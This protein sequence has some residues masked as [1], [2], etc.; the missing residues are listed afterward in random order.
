MTE[1]QLIRSVFLATVPLLV[2]ALGIL[3]VILWNLVK[4]DR[5]ATK[6]GDLAERLSHIEGKIEDRKI[7][8]EPR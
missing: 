4:V 2:S 5:L 7:I 8:L 1:L 3:G 6:V